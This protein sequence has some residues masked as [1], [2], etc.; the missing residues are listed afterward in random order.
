MGNDNRTT[1]CDHP[2][3]VPLM[4]VQKT[5][6]LDIFLLSDISSCIPNKVGKV[7]V[8]ITR[9]HTVNKEDKQEAEGNEDVPTVLAQIVVVVVVGKKNHQLYLRDTLSLNV[10]SLTMRNGVKL[11]KYKILKVM[12]PSLGFLIPMYLAVLYTKSAF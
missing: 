5:S 7:G 3:P 9:T 8:A 1:S 2:Y 12:N 10:D 4:L 11:Q 6:F